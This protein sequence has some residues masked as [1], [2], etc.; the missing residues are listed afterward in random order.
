MNI[1]S[2]SGGWPD[3]DLTWSGIAFYEAVIEDAALVDGLNAVSLTCKTGL[4]AILL[5]WLEADYPRNYAAEADQL[6]FTS[7]SPQRFQVT[8]FSGADLLAFDITEPENVS[9]SVNF[10]TGGS[11]PYSLE[12]TPPN[13]AAQARTYL[14]LSNAALL[15][16]RAMTA[17]AASNLTAAAMRVFWPMPYASGR[18][19]RRSMCCWSVTP[20]TITRITGAWGPAMMCPPT[21]CL[22]SRRARRSPMTGLPGSAAAMPCPTFSSDVCRRPKPS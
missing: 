18:R 14:V 4:D 13:G 9:R 11:G 6:K 22:A 7:G 21:R 16:P 3:P 1:E 17:D 8:D 10:Q 15:T 5:D 20:A 19:W 12:Y 2:S